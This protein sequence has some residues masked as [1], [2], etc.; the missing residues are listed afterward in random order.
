ML[1]QM[2]WEG[3]FWRA[4][5]LISLDMLKDRVLGIKEALGLADGQGHLDPVLCGAVG[6]RSRLDAVIEE[7]VVDEAEGIIIGLDQLVNLDLSQVLTI[8][9]MRGV[10]DCATG[11]HT[12]I[13]NPRTVLFYCIPSYRCLSSSLNWLCF[14][15]I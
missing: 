5:N 4:D 1:V 14:R 2:H 6:Q 13:Y 9:G 8:S 3:P 15:P 12:Q 7:P 10:R 11:Q